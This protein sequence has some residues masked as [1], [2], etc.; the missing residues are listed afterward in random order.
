MPLTPSDPRGQLQ[1]SGGAGVQHV[2][3]HSHQSWLVTPAL[4]SLCQH[5]SP[6]SLQGLQPRSSLGHWGRDSGE[7]AVVRS[8]HRP[9]VKALF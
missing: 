1:R 3:T 5:T 8:S 6:F 4:A 9:G 7:Q 2:P